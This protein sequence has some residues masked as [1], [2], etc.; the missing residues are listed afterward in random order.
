MSF[1]DLFTPKEAENIA[2]FGGD[3]AGRTARLSYDVPLPG[4]YSW[5]RIVPLDLKDDQFSQAATSAG[6]S[7]AELGVVSGDK[8]AGGIVNGEALANFYRRA[9]PAETRPSLRRIAAVNGSIEPLLDQADR[10]Q[11]AAG[12]AGA[13]QVD[14]LG[15]RAVLAEPDDVV[16]QGQRVDSYIQR[17]AAI[18]TT[19]P[20]LDV[21][22]SLIDLPIQGIGQSIHVVQVDP[23]ADARPRLALVETWEIR[24]Y[25]GDYG[26]GRTLQTFSLLPGERT[27]ITVSTWR[28]EAATREDSTSIFDSSDT[29]AQTRFTSSLA[30]QAGSASQE[31]GGWAASVSTSASA[32][33]SFF[34]LVSGSVSVNAGFSANHQEASQRFS[35]SVTQCASEHAAQVNNS[36]RQSVDSASSSTSASGSATTTVREVSN[37]NL[38]R[39]LNF[40]F[41]ELNQTYETYVVLR[42]IKVSFYNGRPGSAEIVPLANL[43]Q[44]LHK[45]IAPAEQDDIARRILGLCAERVDFTGDRVSMLEVGTNPE[46]VS[47]QWA[48][49][50]LQS[51]GLVDFAGETLASDVRW[52]FRSGVLS[53]EEDGREIRGVI[54]DK[55]AMVLRTDNLVVEALLGQADAVDP[56]VSALQA[57]DLFAR[58]GENEARAADVR[59]DVDALDLIAN[60]QAADKIT[61]WQKIFADGPDIEVVSAAAA[62]GH[63]GAPA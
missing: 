61:A 2:Q 12:A 9:L 26:L 4:A 55:S 1:P 47:Y 28:S 49:A 52:R 20:V 16:R 24:S 58:E 53:R 44:L 14:L 43:D 45:Y 32:G 19:L 10:M 15:R 31:S 38:R 8:G 59:H 22:R 29:A 23:M 57:L 18:Q 6:S 25:L 40:V 42:D 51:D 37:T 48:Q 41:R 21:G 3:H 30:N 5:Q 63:N 56:Y 34:G 17:L 39:V 35:N 13:Q 54:M 46:G 11:V 62:A 50:A 36:R 33:A 7:F 27:T 60:Q